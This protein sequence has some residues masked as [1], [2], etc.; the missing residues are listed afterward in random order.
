MEQYIHTLIPVDSTYRP[1]P[2]QVAAFFSWLLGRP[3]FRLMDTR[4]LQRGIIVLK[5]TGRM[6]E[7]K[8]RNPMTGENEMRLRPDPDR[9][10]VQAGEEIPT[11][12]ESSDHFTVW[13]PGEWDSSGL[14]IKLFTTD[15]KP[16]TQNYLCKV[17]CE[18]RPG[19]VSTSAWDVEVGP[20]VR[21]VPSFGSP[22][23]SDNGKGIFPNPWTGEAIEVPH[24]GC[25]RFWIEFEF[26]KFIFPNVDKNLDVLDR[27]IVAEAEQCFQTK[28]VQ[29]C[30]FW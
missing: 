25:A 18:L 26:G 8:F 24:A 1:G 14:P 10:A 28:F 23:T 17:G 19:P 5:F 11:L 13:A 2:A 6:R 15:E 4:H 21:G 29:G 3:N 9:T 16:F 22:C 27:S 7:F 20:N 12:I 30:R